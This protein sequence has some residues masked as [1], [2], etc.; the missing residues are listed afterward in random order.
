MITEAELRRL[1]GGGEQLDVE[2]RGEEAAALADVELVEAVVCLANARGGTLLVGVEDDGR[3]TGARPRHGS[4]TDVGRLEALVGNRTVPNCPVDCSIV[5][6]DGLD[7]LVVRVPPARPVT[8]TTDGVYRR[9]ALDL[10]GRPR[11]VPFLHHEIQSR[12]ASRGALD[13]TALVVPEARW[14]D[15]DPLE[16]E[17][18]RQTIAKAPGRADASLALLSDPE[19]VK[20]LGLGE[21]GER[22]ERVRV[23]GLLLLGRESALRRFLPTHEVAFQVLSGT[24]VVMN[25]FFRG[26]LIRVADE[27]AARFAA[28]NEEEELAVGPLRVGVPRYSPAG[29]REAVHNALVHRDYTRLGAVHVQWRADEVEVG[30]PG[31]FVDSVRLENLLVTVPTPR[32][33]V[34]ADAFKRI[35]LVERTGRGID[36]IYEGQLRYG[37]PAPD[38][39]RSTVGSVQVVLPTGP[40]NSAVARIIVEHDTPARRMSVDEMIAIN[41]VEREG[42]LDLERA[43]ELMQRSEPAVAAVLDRLVDAGVL[44][45]RSERRA[46]VYEFAESILQGALAGVGAPMRRAAADSGQREEVV[47]QYVTA[48]GRITRS[49]AA[50]LCQVEGRE[51]RQ[52]LEKLVKRGALVVKGERRGS[53]YELAGAADG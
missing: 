48:N 51:A 37:R 26:P 28:R 35:G 3:V 15:L 8:C 53:Y 41:A 11:C 39:S 47:L 30:S 6:L 25:D 16:F 4:Y 36:T 24:R 22:V 52:V 17:R 19:I 9:R 20:A 1:I 50:D 45:A 10:H 38:Y 49:Q 2:F 21:G 32:N 29:L 18:L 42:E 31:G 13:Y 5:P 46:R 33:P 23:A 12:E 34:L 44:E 40:A 14:E 43:A 7:L 27:I